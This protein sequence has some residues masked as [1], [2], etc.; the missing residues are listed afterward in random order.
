MGCYTS[1]VGLIKGISEESYE[2]I[3]QDLERT[4]GEVNYKNGIIDISSYGKHF[5]IEPVFDKIAFCIDEGGGQLIEIGDD[6]DKSVIFFAPRV[7]A[8]KHVKVVWPE[9]PFEKHKIS[10]KE[11]LQTIV[12]DYAMF[13]ECARICMEEREEKDVTKLARLQKQEN[14]LVLLCQLI[15]CLD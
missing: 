6:D 10:L 7:W 4:F 11:A 13:V 14:S 5:Q 8:R 2:L 15:I 1:I 3:R 12:E 9:N